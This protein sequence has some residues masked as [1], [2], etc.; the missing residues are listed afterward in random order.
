MRPI[1]HLSALAFL[2]PPPSPGLCLLYLDVR[3]RVIVAPAVSAA[4]THYHITARYAVQMRNISPSG[5]Q[6]YRVTKDFSVSHS[7]WAH[8]GQTVQVNHIMSETGNPRSAV[9]QQSLE[10]TSCVACGMV[11]GV[12]FGLLFGMLPLAMAIEFVGPALSADTEGSMWECGQLW[13]IVAPL[14]IGCP[15]CNLACARRATAAP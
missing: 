12:I 15:L 7:C 2:K 4:T 14:L 13:A 10:S 11:F 6:F 3:H 8:E 1:Q 9:L 5:A